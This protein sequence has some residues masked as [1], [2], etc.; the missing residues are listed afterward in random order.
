MQGSNE[1]TAVGE[2]TPANIWN[3]SGHLAQFQHNCLGCLPVGHQLAAISFS[4]AC[5][6]QLQRCKALWE[7]AGANRAS[8]CIYVTA[9]TEQN[10]NLAELAREL[11]EQGEIKDATGDAVESGFDSCIC[12]AFACCRVEHLLVFVPFVVLK[13]QHVMSFADIRTAWPFSAITMTKAME[14]KLDHSGN[15]ENRRCLTPTGISNSCPGQF[16]GD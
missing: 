14:I 16:N 3:R 8:Q 10:S 12:K 11:S 5:V 4:V 1:A 2:A 13:E 7:S 9:F 15:R 6:T